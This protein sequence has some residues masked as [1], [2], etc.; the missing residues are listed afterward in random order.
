MGQQSGGGESGLSW[1]EDPGGVGQMQGISPC[2]RLL[3]TL[4]PSTHTKSGA[5]TPQDEKQWGAMV[6]A[7][8]IVRVI[9]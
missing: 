8:G 6:P 1:K 2:P 3:S 4:G 5:D 7:K 9:S